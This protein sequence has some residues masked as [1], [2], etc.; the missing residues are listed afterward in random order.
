MA[1]KSMYY[2]TLLGRE[3]EPRMRIYEEEFQGPERSA[4]HR[5]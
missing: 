4:D 2:C 5:D 1:G 3:S